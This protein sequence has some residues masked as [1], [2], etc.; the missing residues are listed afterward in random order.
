MSRV[1][2]KELF[3]EWRRLQTSIPYVY[4]AH[5]R[6]QEKAHNYVRHFYTNTNMRFKLL[7]HEFVDRNMIYFAI[8]EY[9]GAEYVI[10]NSGPRLTNLKFKK[11][12]YK[13]M[14]NLRNNL[15]AV[16]KK[17]STRKLRC[18]LLLYMRKRNKFNN[19]LEYV[20][21]DLFSDE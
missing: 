20:T 14:T 9:L 13:K 3:T 7:L 19:L 21:F 5:D 18:E 12:F 2:Y 8:F 15:L 6:A 16:I 4:M 1:E 11:W 17:V 10:K